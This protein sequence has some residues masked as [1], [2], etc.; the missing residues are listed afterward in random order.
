MRA[1][2][3]DVR[4]GAYGVL[5]GVVALAAGRCAAGSCLSCFACAVPGALALL[6]AVGPRPGPKPV[7]A[8][9]G[10]PAPDEREGAPRSCASCRREPGCRI[11]R[12]TAGEVAIC[13]LWEDK[14][15]PR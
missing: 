14:E 9:A 1:L 2:S 5:S 8:P 13:N 3:R 10:G 12:Y 11:A 15:A 4:Y 6:A 7:P